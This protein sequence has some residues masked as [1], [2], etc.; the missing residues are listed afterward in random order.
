MRHR[1]LVAGSLLCFLGLCAASSEPAP[2][3]KSVLDD[4]PGLERRV[5]FAETKISLGELLQRV[6]KETG[7]RVYADRSTADEPAA[8]VVTDM[9]AAQLLNQLAQLFDYRWG[10]EAAASGPRYRLYQDRKQQAD[11]EAQRLAV[12]ADEQRRL[13]LVLTGYVKAGRLT[14]EQYAVQRE[15]LERRPPGSPRPSVED[16]RLFRGLRECGDPAKRALARLLGQLTQQ[17]WKVLWQGQRLHLYSKPEAGQRG[18]PPDVARSVAGLRPSASWDVQHML[19]D[20]N[21]KPEYV[22]SLRQMYER[23][24]QQWARADGVRVVIRLRRAAEM[25]RNSRDRAAPSLTAAMVPLI[26]NPP[27][28]QPVQLSP[29]E[30]NVWIWAATTQPRWGYDP[31]ERTAALEKDPVFSASKPFN[32]R[33]P[34]RQDWRG[35]IAYGQVPDLLPEMSRTYGVSFLSDSYWPTPV[36]WSNAFPS[37]VPAP[38]PAVNGA[39]PPAAAP[40]VPA[41]APEPITLGALLAKLSGR[42]ENDIKRITYNYYRWDRDDKLVL[43]RDR[44]W[45]MDRPKEV[46]ARLITRWNKLF[47]ERGGLPIDEYVDG[48]AALTDDQWDGLMEYRYLP[49]SLPGYDRIPVWE[50]DRN[51]LRL[52]HALTPA[53]RQRLLRGAPIPW[54]ELNGVQRELFLTVVEDQ[55][56]NSSTAATPADLAGADFF[57]S[58]WPVDLVRRKQGESIR[59]QYVT[60]GEDASH[61][62]EIFEDVPP[63]VAQPAP[64]APAALPITYTRFPMSNVRLMVRCGRIETAMTTFAVASTRR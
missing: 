22:T 31:P 2:R 18:L 23:Q 53:Q 7:A 15:A 55:S 64:N 59:E 40:P 5:T 41:P 54:T 39:A 26:N 49:A 37:P 28:G 13:E 29:Q 27:G 8:V 45:F 16:D 48:V 24:D 4:V 1:I 30:I 57:M 62:P 36:V 44:T 6:A 3:P 47:T 58:I 14:D 63:N 38:A 25:G 12:H 61:F 10:R 21:L 9:P 50:T 34:P 46:P 60:A 43:L 33:T 35:R 56:L 42:Y 17:D 32:I 19:A 52:F 11:E 51:L 20:P